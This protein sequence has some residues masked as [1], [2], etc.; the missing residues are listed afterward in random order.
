MIRMRKDGFVRFSCSSEYENGIPELSNRL[1]HGSYKS[2]GDIT[3]CLSLFHLGDSDIKIT[4]SALVRT[5]ICQDFPTPLPLSLPTR[6]R[7]SM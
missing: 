3:R 2:S 6:P 4:P 7:L 5:L 1:F